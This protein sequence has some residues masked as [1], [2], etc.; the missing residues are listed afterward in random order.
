MLS[1]ICFDYFYKNSMRFHQNF[2]NPAWR[3]LDN[4]QITSISIV[5]LYLYKVLYDHQI[6]LS[7]TKLLIEDF[8]SRSNIQPQ[9]Y[10]AVLLPGRRKFV[11][12][13]DNYHNKCSLDRVGAVQAESMRKFAIEDA[14]FG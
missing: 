11:T 10:G 8:K 9:S 4:N 12:E 3:R 5:S 6:S 13:D 7:V 14:N 1:C 2:P